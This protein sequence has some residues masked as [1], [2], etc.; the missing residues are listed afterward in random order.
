MDPRFRYVGFTVNPQLSAFKNLGKSIAVGEAGVGG[1]YCAD[2]TLRLDSIG[3]S[4][5][6]IP[7]PK[8]I[9]RKWSSIGGSNDQPIGSSLCLRFHQVPQIARGAQALHTLQCL[10]KRK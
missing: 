8:G 5:P 9:K 1:S 6:S 2:T 7:A 4:V 10:S 3:S